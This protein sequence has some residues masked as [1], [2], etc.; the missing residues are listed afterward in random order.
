MV[1]LYSKV[2]LYSD[3]Y[4]YLRHILENSLQ[5]Y[6]LEVSQAIPIN[7]IHMTDSLIDKQYRYKINAT[8]NITR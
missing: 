6:N 7:L 8:K 5:V 1:P 3:Y 2:P 4:Q